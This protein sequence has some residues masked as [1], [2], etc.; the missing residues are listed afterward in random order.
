MRLR[1]LYALLTSVSMIHLSMAA[2]DSACATHG[3]HTHHASTASRA[4]TA[5]H[6]IAGHVMPMTEAAGGSTPSSG[7]VAKADLPPC[8]RPA[9]QHCCD[10]VTGCGGLGAV[11]SAPQALASVVRRAARIRDALHD[12]PASFASAPEPPPPKA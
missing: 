5:G 6:A 12:A 9:Q 4:A 1:R 7:P 11:T 8:E 3:A 10:A 2:G